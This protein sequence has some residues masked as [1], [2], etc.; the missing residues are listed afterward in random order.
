MIELVVATRN[1]GKLKEIRRLLESRGIKVLGLDS[2]PAVPD[3]V[4]DGAT[5]AANALKKAETVA[6]VT[7][8]P[9]LAD[10]SGLVVEA[11]HGRPGVH[12]A[13]FSG[14]D[15]DDQSNNRKLLAEM[16]TVPGSRRQAAFRCV[17]ALCMPG[18]PPHLFEGRVNGMILEREQGDGGFGYDPLFWLPDHNC[19]MA[20]LPL[21]TKNR[22][23][24]RGQALRQV[25]DFLTDLAA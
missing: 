16:A 4:E 3:V 18:Q 6:R 8:L 7:G 21:D 1:A 15:A 24:H 10:D 19:T 11:L 2:F 5:F 12:S 22:I 25:V 13:R 23:S 14:D 17:M 9:C 20:E